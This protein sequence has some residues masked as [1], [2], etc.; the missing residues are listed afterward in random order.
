MRY[1]SSEQ[2]NVTVDLL[3][4]ER[5]ELTGQ[6]LVSARIWGSK[7]TW[8]LQMKVYFEKR[9]GKWVIVKQVASTY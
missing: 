9:A 7:G 8:R 5:A 3:A 2:E 1:Y 4:E 6:N